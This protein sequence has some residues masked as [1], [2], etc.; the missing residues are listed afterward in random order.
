[1]LSLPDVGY[2]IREVGQGQRSSSSQSRATAAQR[3]RRRRTR[4]FIRRM[5]ATS[6]RQGRM[7]QTNQWSK[8]VN[9]RDGIWRRSAQ[10]A[11]SGLFPLREGLLVMATWEAEAP[12]RVE[13]SVRDKSE[14]GSAPTK[15]NRERAGD[16][17]RRRTELKTAKKRAKKGRESKKRRSRKR[18]KQKQK[19]QE[20][21]KRWGKKA[22]MRLD[23]EDSHSRHGSGP[24]GFLEP[25]QSKVRYPRL[26]PGTF[27]GAPQLA[28]GRWG[29][30]A[31]RAQGWHWLV[32]A[33][34]CAAR[35]RPRRARY[36]NQNLQVSA[37]YLQL[38]LRASASNC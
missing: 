2:N 16:E 9:Q 31:C 5:Q 25:P 17:N 38:V 12:L 24:V 3:I 7:K 22:E 4:L 23:A 32:A 35:A 20:A 36:P 34:L 1:M 29:Q 28:V 6:G 11:V 14:S 21:R 33:I 8:P 27:F 18:E 30:A 37:P 15:R 26:T 19:K 10:P 13:E